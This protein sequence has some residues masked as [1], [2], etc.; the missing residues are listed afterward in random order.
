MVWVLNF[1]ILVYESYCIGSLQESSTCMRL[2]R[3]ALYSRICG[4]AHEGFHCDP[5]YL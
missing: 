4:Y 5:P 1:H 3:K 2:C